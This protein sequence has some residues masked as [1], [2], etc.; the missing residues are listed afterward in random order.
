[1][2]EAE[3]KK[4]GIW[5]RR[6]F[7]T[8]LGWGGFGI[9]GLGILAGFVRSAFPRV[10][11]QPPATFKA[12]VPSDYAIGE[13]SEKYKQEQ[14]V[15]I[16]REKEGIY[17]IFAKCTHLGCTP[18]WLGA[19]EKFKCPCHGSGYYKSGLNFE[20]PAPRPMDRFKVE[21]AED[22]QLVVDKSVI[23]KMQPGVEPDEQFPQSVLKV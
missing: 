7:F 23:F 5:S 18:R 16:V 3:K 8:R 1:M 19:E 15:W 21:V 6:D 9:F 2:A 12:G 11:F 14:R 17:A 22:G 10:L 13:V 4:F 20:G